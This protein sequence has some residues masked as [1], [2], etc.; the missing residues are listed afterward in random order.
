MNR[1]VVILL[2][3]LIIMPLNVEATW[4]MKRLTWNSGKS[5]SAD[6]TVDSNDHIHIV[7]QDD[8]HGNYEIY[9]KK[10]ID[11]GTTWV[12]K[13]LTW[14]SS[15]T[16]DPS[17][18]VDV[19]N[20]IHVIYFEYIH[21]D[22]EIYKKKSTDG[23]KSWATESLTWNSVPTEDPALAI[24]THNQIHKVGHYKIHE[25]YEI[26][27]KTGI[28]WDMSLA[29]Q[30]LTWTSGCSKYPAIAVDSNNIVH[31]V[32]EDNTPGNYEIYYMK[33]ISDKR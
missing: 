17:I 27:Y 14:T 22:Y 8:T 29:A 12:T 24:D 13:R 20:Q 33:S 19:N 18:I 7:Y 3:G 11:E 25:N 21:G 5:Y 31:V 10:S 23:G 6:I 32:W 4:V 28:D 2:L 15:L 16:E 9:Y 1:Q 30:R 26:Y